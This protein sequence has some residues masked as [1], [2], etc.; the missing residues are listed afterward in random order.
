MRA[1]A[2]RMR[3]WLLASTL[4]SGLPALASCERPLY[5][6]FDTGHMG[7]APL[8]A[9]VLARQ[10]VRATFFAAH[11]KTQAGDGSLGSAW[12]PWW[13]ERAAQGHAFASHT[14]DHAYWVA[15]LP[16]REGQ[17]R[18]RIRPSA[19][20]QQGQTLTWSAAQY[21]EELHRASRRLL[22][23]TGQ[24][25]LPLFRAPGGKTSPALVKAAQACGYLHVGWPQGQGLLFC[26]PARAPGLP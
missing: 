24:T 3:R 15:D 6:T 1:A 18:F 14:H 13:K 10:Q 20:P 9:E 7:V 23:I 22:E 25:P 4:L 21:C 19:G 8:I 12:G 16:A 11:E 2:D 17:P 5:L 26:H